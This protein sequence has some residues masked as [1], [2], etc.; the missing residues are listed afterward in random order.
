MLFKT[1]E[2]FGRW[3]NTAFRFD[4]TPCLYSFTGGLDGKASACN[5]GDPGSIPGLGRFPGEGNGNPLQYSCLE[6]L[7]DRGAWRATVVHEVSKSQRPL[8]NF[9]FTCLYHFF[10]VW[11]ANILLIWLWFSSQLKLKLREE[12][13]TSHIQKAHILKH[14]F[15]SVFN[16]IKTFVFTY[17]FIDI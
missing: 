12:T 3:C 7:M 11:I 8:S 10:I 4:M 2:E 6:N 17:N 14:I 13:N 9:T 1:W 5:V 16:S 15:K